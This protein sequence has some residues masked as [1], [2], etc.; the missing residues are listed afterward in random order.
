[1]KLFTNG[2][3]RVAL[4]AAVC[5]ATLF[6][7]SVEAQVLYGSVV[8]SAQ[9]ASGAVVPNIQ[10]SLTNSETGT[11]REATTDASGNYTVGNLLP[12]TYVLKATGPGFRTITRPGLEVQANNVARVDFNMEVGQVTDRCDRGIGSTAPDRR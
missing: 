3:W 12:G 6:T 5:F 8:G 4:T 1:M 9:D 11:T 2:L 10:I 7:S